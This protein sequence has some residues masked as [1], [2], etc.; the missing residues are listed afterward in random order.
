[1]AVELPNI[2][3]PFVDPDGKVNR[4][5][6]LALLSL[7]NQ[8]ATQMV[9]SV[10]ITGLNGIT[11]AG[12]PITSAG[13][14]TLGIG[15]LTCANAIIAGTLTAANVIVT[16]AFSAANI[17]TG[18]LTAAN[19]VVSGTVTSAHVR[20]GSVIATG[21]VTAADI[22]ATGTIKPASTGGI[23]GTATNDNANAGSFGE[24]AFAQVLSAAAVNLTSGTALTVTGVNLTAGDWDVSGD[25][26]FNLIGITTLTNIA[27]AISVTTNTMPG[28]DGGETL[29]A[30]TFTTGQTQ[31][32]HTP[33][34]RAT[35][36]ANTPYYLVA[37]SAFAVSSNSVSGMIRAR[38]VR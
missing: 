29:L 17:A 24:Y 32:L 19:V 15:N 1:M 4:V 18:T 2:G 35:L 14:F 20:T 36:N 16:S 8:V 3:Q 31:V 23:I 5:W 30:T 10:N 13:I 33:L 34:V 38:R 21:T 6:Y 37:R 28:V 22:V 11:S 27:V 9:T 7:N 12:G 26:A 25:V